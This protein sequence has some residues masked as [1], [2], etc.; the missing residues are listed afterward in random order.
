MALIDITPALSAATPMWPGDAPFKAARTWSIEGG[1][2]VNVSLLTMSSHAGAHADAPLHYHAG[3]ASI[4]AV[5]LEPYIG[6]CA[7]LHCI[8]ERPLILPRHVASA[9]GRLGAETVERVLIRTY[10]TTPAKW[11]SAFAAIHPDTI[12]WLA[13]RGARIIGVD[14][15]SLDPETSKTMDAHKRILAADMRV[16]ENLLLDHVQ[17]GFYELI[18]PPLKLQGLDAAPVRAVLRT[19]E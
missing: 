17:E 10:G 3:G 15:P 16:L 11:D 8:G 4:D 14:T 13:A 19:L 6:R 18:A 5:A 1:G 2:A 7:V 9:F 12:D